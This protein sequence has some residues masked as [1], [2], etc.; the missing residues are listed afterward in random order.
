M[1]LGEAELIADQNVAFSVVRAHGIR[2]T[3]TSEIS[4]A[5]ATDEAILQYAA[6][7]RAVVVT[8][9]SDFGHLVAGSSHPTYGIVY[10]RPGALTPSQVTDA[11]LQLQPFDV[12]PP[13]ALVARVT[14]NLVSVR[15][16]PLT[17][18]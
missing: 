9:D 12:E 13:F 4:M 1:K 11:I 5:R 2:I 14:A 10:I 17:T 16:R 15:Y 8:H 7:R 18:P 6:E 3:R